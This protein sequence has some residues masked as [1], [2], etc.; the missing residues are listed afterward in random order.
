MV[1]PEAEELCDNID[2]NCDGKIDNI[3]E[4]IVEDDFIFDT[5]FIDTG[6]QIAILTS[7]SFMKIK[8][9]MVLVAMLSYQDVLHLQKE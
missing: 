3:D 9:M 1:Y 8:I 7:R 4:E 5:G 2:N 6:I